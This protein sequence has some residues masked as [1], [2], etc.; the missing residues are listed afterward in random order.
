M[1][2]KKSE[3]NLVSSDVVEREI[4]E[5]ESEGIKHNL[6]HYQEQPFLYS[7]KTHLFGV[8]MLFI[9]P[10]SVAAY[11]VVKAHDADI[12][13]TQKEQKGVVFLQK[14]VPVFYQVSAYLK[15]REQKG[16]DNPVFDAFDEQ[17]DREKRDKISQ[18]LAQLQKDWDIDQQGL[19]LEKD[20]LEKQDKIDIHIEKIAKNWQKNQIESDQAVLDR[21]QKLIIYV[22][23]T[24]NLI[25]DPDL[26]T[27]YLMDLSV[28]GLT[29]ALSRLY[30]MPPVASKELV[31]QTAVLRDSDWVRINA[32]FTSAR[33]EDARYY[34]E[35]DALQQELPKILLKTQQSNDAL[36]L[37]L[38][39]LYEEQQ[40]LKYRRQVLRSVLQLIDEQQKLHLAA[41][42]TLGDMLQARV[43]FLLEQKQDDVTRA[44]ASG[45][46]VAALAVLV[47]ARTTKRLRSL[48]Q[49]MERLRDD[50]LSGRLHL[51]GQDE[52]SMLSQSFNRKAES[53]E[54]LYRKNREQRQHLNARNEEM[55][56]ILD[57]VA[58]GL[59]TVDQNA[60]ICGEHSASIEKWLGTPKA[61]E[62]FA[63]YVERTDPA[64]G[65][66][67]R[68]GWESVEDGVLV[69]DLALDQL[70]S[71]IRIGDRHIRVHCT[72]IGVYT[73]D[74]P[75]K[76]YLLILSDITEYVEREKA[77]AVQRDVL[78][79]LDKMLQDRT[80]VIEFM[81]DSTELT[82][83]IVEEKNMTVLK[84]RIHTLKG[85]SS[86]F[87]VSSVVDVCHNIET[88]MLN[89][90]RLPN[91]DERQRIFRAWEQI[92]ERIKTFLENRSE[93]NIEIDDDDIQYVLH[94][95]QENK[96]HE[97]IYQTIQDW[98]H[99]PVRRRLSRVGNQAAALARRLDKGDINV[100][101]EDNRIRLP[102]GVWPEFWASFSH[103]IRNAVDH[104]LESADER[105]KVGKK[106]KGTITL[107]TEHVVYPER[108]ETYLAVTLKDDGRGI[109]WEK[110]AKKAKEL[111]L[112]SSTQADLEAALFADGVSTKEQASDISG[113]GVGT[114]ALKTSVENAGGWMRIESTL[115]AGTSFTF[116]LPVIQHSQTATAPRAANTD[117]PKMID[118]KQK[119]A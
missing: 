82:R 35:N 56:L 88:I 63:D 45:G 117:G 42:A 29:S 55:S 33:N 57:N 97:E 5:Q 9:L 107:R 24:S 43:D 111:G 14:Y 46:L 80:G 98:Y 49:Q 37:S 106:S 99:E 21:L 51:S 71:L 64:F 54:K 7:I 94:S 59:L 4:S 23:D 101:I 68:L 60:V 31:E 85:N 15:G 96:K 112:P 119:S 72:P 116:Y 12:E 30:T 115:G 75:P 61:H 20:E 65:E 13:F 92:N 76:R 70:P 36:L 79:L 109:Q 44:Y 100:V 38:N 87:G 6:V 83:H 52:L 58:E 108:K 67:F 91:A 39:S 103:A 95:L 26:D 41:L 22:G 19:R 17:E 34:G 78:G 110:I 25:L 47:I 113:R 102:Y 73:D 89:D 53:V 77:E 8:L 69:L 90:H 118:K 62:S 10:I 66:W 93:K 81:N 27:Y 74:K 1:N 18:E 105:N 86:L 114:S 2:T 40:N 48:Q 104:G 11:G 3:K 84:R 32:A 50:D 16:F 28:S